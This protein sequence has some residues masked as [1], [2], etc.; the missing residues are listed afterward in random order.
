ML[1]LILLKKWGGGFLFLPCHLFSSSMSHCCLFWFREYWHQGLGVLVLT[2][3][4]NHYT[5]WAFLSCYWYHWEVVN[6]NK[7]S[8]KHVNQE[9][10]QHSKDIIVVRVLL[11]RNSP[12][13]QWA[14]KGNQERADRLGGRSKFLLDYELLASQGDYPSGSDVLLW[15]EKEK[16]KAS[17]WWLLA[18]RI[19]GSNSEAREGTGGSWQALVSQCFP[20]PPFQWSGWSSWELYFKGLHSPGLTI[21]CPQCLVEVTSLLLSSLLPSSY[22]SQ[23]H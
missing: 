1:V 18:R 7:I 8:T 3:P 9:L 12:W 22:S 21:L 6:N 15:V 17:H 13:F 14:K 2:L 5:L 4:E 11:K 20:Q 23:L 10:Y 19:S 16:V